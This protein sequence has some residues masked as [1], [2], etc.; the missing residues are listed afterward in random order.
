MADGAGTDLTADHAA[1]ASP[2]SGPCDLSADIRRVNAPLKASKAYIAEVVAQTNSTLPGI[3]G[4]GPVVA[5]Q[6]VGRTGRA[7][8]FPTAAAF[9][10]YCGTAPLEVF[11][12]DR[13]GTGCHSRAIGNSTTLCTPSRWPG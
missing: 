6:L 7:S 3:N 5:A 10:S 2:A 8:R 13:A 9:A 12:G 4:V 11:S 1:T